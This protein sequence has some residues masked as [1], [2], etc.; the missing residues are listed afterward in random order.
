MSIYQQTTIPYF[1]VIK[2]ISSGKLYA[3]SRWAKGC[4]PS[5]LLQENGYLTSSKVV[6]KMLMEDPQCFEVVMIKTDCENVK[7]FETMFIE[8]NDC[9]SSTL[10]LNGHNNK[11]LFSHDSEEFKQI[12][13]K[14]YGTDHW[15]KT[16]EGREFHRQQMIAYNQTEVAKSRLADLNKNNNPSKKES[17]R[18]TH[19]KLMKSMNQKMLSNGTHPSLK[20]ENKE[21]AS[22]KMKA[23]MA[24]QPELICPH[25][26]RSS[27]NKSN[28]LRWHFYNCKFK[29]SDHHISDSQESNLSPTNF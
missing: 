11:I 4:N 20:K 21:K 10:W 18:A 6:K 14:L 23:T 1:Y 3:G 17:N 29:R 13:I 12:M 22:I 28:M 15:V 7:E 8:E 5:E 16:E 2:H 9:V 25:C 26:G 19:S 27:K 24:N